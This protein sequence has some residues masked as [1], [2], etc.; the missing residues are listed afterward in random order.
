MS[1]TELK[2]EI[3][4]LQSPQLDEVAALILQIRRARDP[5]RKEKLAEMI[6]GNDWVQW[7]SDRTG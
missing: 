4:S 3:K 7:K 1:L 5:D 2:E 6:D